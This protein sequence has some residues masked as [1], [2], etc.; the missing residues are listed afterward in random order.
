MRRARGLPLGT[1]APR[2]GEEGAAGSC[3]GRAR[4]RPR[5]SGGR[6]PPHG[7]PAAAVLR[8]GRAAQSAEAPQG[9]G[10][11]R[12]LPVTRFVIDNPPLRLRGEGAMRV[13]REH[14]RL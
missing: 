3:Q 14:G 1:S 8:A 11:A 13:G 2:G 10:G 7:A 4:P 5:A 12:P 6:P 9:G